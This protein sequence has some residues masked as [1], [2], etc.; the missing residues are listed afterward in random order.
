M[1]CLKRFQLPKQ[2]KD[3][4]LFTVPLHS[5]KRQNRVEMNEALMSSGRREIPFF[6]YPALFKSR[7]KEIMDT[8]YDVMNR[9]AYVLQK[10]LKQFEEALKDFLSVKYAYG[11]DLKMQ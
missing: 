6:N 11:V 9:G 2:I 3:I 5:Q 7:E 4:K 1:W 8:L 10:D